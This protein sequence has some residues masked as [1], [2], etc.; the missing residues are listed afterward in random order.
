MAVS[1]VKG[2]NTPLTGD[3]PGLERILVGL[4]WDMNPDPNMPDLDLDI[5]AFVTGADGICKSAE[6]FVF[7][8]NPSFPGGAV[9]IF[10][11]S[12]QGSEVG[13]DEQI[14]IQL[15]SLPAEIEKIEIAASIYDA[16]N[17]RQ[18][19]SQVRNAYLS[20]LDENTNTELA[21]FDMSNEF[22]IETAVIA[23]EFYRH[24]GQWRFNAIGMGYA[25]GIIG[26]CNRHGIEAGYY[27]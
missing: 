21:R 25:G 15:N 8:G 6:E 1:L 10:N 18:N 17:R 3:N 7:Y 26:I 4:G 19:F 5:C 2:Q 9:R 23:G 11:D 16:E 14:E 27:G 20:I 13:Y 24:L 12:L 22:S